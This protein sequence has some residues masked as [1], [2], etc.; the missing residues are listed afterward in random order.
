MAPE[1]LK[2]NKPDKRVPGE[3]PPRKRKQM[4]KL[5]RETLGFALAGVLAMSVDLAVF[6]LLMS[7]D[8]NASVA[9]ASA[10]FSA[11]LI[12]F[13]VNHRAFVPGKSI[14]KGLTKKSVRFGAVAAVSAVFLFAGFEIALRTLP[15][16]S[17]TTYSVIRVFLIGIGTI[18]RFLALKFWVF[19]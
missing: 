16:Q 3:Y 12:N 19:R 5:A 4:R 14:R 13:L 18:A 6:N 2:G 1:I 11:L 17:V 8:T 15:E 9:N 10:T 7:R